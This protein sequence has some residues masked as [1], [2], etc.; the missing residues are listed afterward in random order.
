MPIFKEV[1]NM[2]K[3]VNKIFWIMHYFHLKLEYDK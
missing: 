2:C 1:S 3:V